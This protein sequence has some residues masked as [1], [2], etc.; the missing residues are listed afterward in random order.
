VVPDLDVT[1]SGDGRPLVLLHSLLQDRSSFD[2]LAQRLQGQRRVCNV[3]LPGFGASPAAEPLAGYADRLA[4]GL[5]RLGVDGGA[6]I[7]G[8][9][10]G[11]FVALTLAD[12]H[13]HRAGRLVL[14][15]SAIRFPEAGR[16]TFRAMAERAE[17]E[18]MAPL[19]DQAMLRM[20]PADYIGAHPERIAPMRRVFQ[21]IDPRVFAAACR[22]LA[23]L[24][25]GD[26]LSRIRQPV[27]VVV[28]EQDAATGAALGEALARSLP[29]GEI[30]VVK[31]AGHAP[32]MQAPD[33]FVAAV[34]PFLELRA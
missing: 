11:G 24:D 17:A 14:V 10:L 34:A 1:I 32:H 25:L 13:P 26:D 31:G 15:G 3:N 29:R 30:V 18:G 21:S 6:D 2:E 33:A 12:R 20:F 23:A 19:T 16:A 22:A 5:D 4:E 27:L 28:G 9:G 7:C 8:N